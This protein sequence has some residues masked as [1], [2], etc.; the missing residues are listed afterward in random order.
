LLNIK[1]SQ[2]GVMTRLRYGGILN[3]PIIF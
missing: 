3:A 2:G 1:I